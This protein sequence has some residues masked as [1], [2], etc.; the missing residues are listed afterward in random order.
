MVKKTELGDKGNASRKSYRVRREN[1]LRRF[2]ISW[3]YFSKSRCCNFECLLREWSRHSY[4][5]HR[6]FY[7]WCCLLLLGSL[8]T[9][10]DKR[11]EVSLIQLY[12]LFNSKISKTLQQLTPILGKRSVRI[13]SKARASHHKVEGFLSEWKRDYTT[14]SRTLTFI[15]KPNYL[16]T[17]PPNLHQSQLSFFRNSKCCCLVQPKR[18][19]LLFIFLCTYSHWCVVHGYNSHEGH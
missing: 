4:Q 8:C 1:D 5:R 7:W 3:C 16:I 10:Y 15:A 9:F 12:P 18:I 2:V 17:T 19:P 13:A 14:W 6:Q 11:Y